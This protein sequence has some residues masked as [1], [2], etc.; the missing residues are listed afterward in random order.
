MNKLTICVSKPCKKSLKSNQNRQSRNR[1]NCLNTL[2]PFV[3]LNLSKILIFTYTY[4]YQ[5]YFFHKKCPHFTKTILYRSLLV[6]QIVHSNDLEQL[7]IQSADI[8]KRSYLTLPAIKQQIKLIQPKLS[9]Q[10]TLSIQQP[11]AVVHLS[12]SSANFLFFALFHI[13]LPA[14]L[15]GENFTR[16]TPSK[17]R[18]KESFACQ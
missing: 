12:F 18:A 10:L 9:P 11:V 3:R 15:G 1:S 14:H 13:A 16:S 2:R 8:V 5:Y 7:R 4:S 17:I 6:L